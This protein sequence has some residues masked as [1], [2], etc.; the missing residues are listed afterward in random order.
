MKNVQIV[1]AFLVIAVA[2]AAVSLLMYVSNSIAAL[3]EV[4][5]GTPPVMQTEEPTP[6]IVESGGEIILT[7]VPAIGGEITASAI[8][9]NPIAIAVLSAILFG[10]IGIVVILMIMGKSE[11]R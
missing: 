7:P 5:L 9:Q 10:T 3:P 2:S 1:K 11:K 8:L 6:Q 4:Q